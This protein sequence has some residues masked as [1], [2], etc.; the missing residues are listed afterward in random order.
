MIKQL[1][2]S[3]LMTGFAAAIPYVVGTIGIG[4]LRL[5]HRSNA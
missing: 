2:L 3:N 5:H 1:G 4:H